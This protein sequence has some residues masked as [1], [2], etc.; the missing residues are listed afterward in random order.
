MVKNILQAVLVILLAI[1]VV[2]LRKEIIGAIETLYQTVQGITSRALAARKEKK[3]DK[4]N[5]K[6]Q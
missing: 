5:K 2:V 4:K 6:K 3:E 1:V